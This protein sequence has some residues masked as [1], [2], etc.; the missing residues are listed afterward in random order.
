VN[1][2]NIERTVKQKTLAISTR[3]SNPYTPHNLPTGA[4][5]TE[6]VRFEELSEK[7]TSSVFEVEQ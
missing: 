4:N 1:F 2:I 5:D 7:H 3:G 6:V